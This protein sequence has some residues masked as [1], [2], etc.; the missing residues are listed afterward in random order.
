MIG[1]DRSGAISGVLGKIIPK[2]GKLI[3]KNK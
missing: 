3:I 1:Q 2:M